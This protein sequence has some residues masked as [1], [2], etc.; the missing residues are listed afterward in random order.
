[1]PKRPD[2]LIVG[3]GVVGCAAAYELAKAGLAVAVVERG[4]PGCEASSAAAGMLSPQ[5]AVSAPNPM[6]N[7]G[8][9]SHALWGDLAS[10]LRERTGVDVEYRTGGSLHCFLDEGDEAVGRATFGWQHAAGLRA[11]MLSRE[12][13][14]ALEPSL[15]R[16]L[17]G[18]LLLPEDHWLNNP[19]L[20]AALA[21]AASFEGVEFIRAEVSALL[22]R[23][24]RVVGVS[25]G[26]SELSAGGVL[27]AAGAW[28]GQLAASAGLTI[29]VHPVRGQLLCLETTPR[30]L[31]HVLHL[32][33]HY[34]VPRVSGELLVGSSME[35]VGFVKQVTGEQLRAFLDTA[36]RLVP[37]LGP[38]PLK[39]SWAGFRPWAPDE[40]PV[41]GP[42]AGLEGL[43]VAT[44]HF[45]NGILLAPVTAR[46]IKELIVDGKA[47]SDLTPFLPDRFV[48]EPPRV[49]PPSRA[50]RGGP[51]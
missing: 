8:L 26:G 4:V 6:L 45:R 27:L 29:P 20:V 17:R 50:G 14:L 5:S 32:K 24:D 46:L 44:A 3:G 51:P 18:A 34:A 33:D 9:A 28:S 16:E 12:D 25:A 37:A 47:S 43:F 30:R 31:H 42:W 10:E 7:L 36:I 22:R 23:G 19:R 21:Q 40:R 1:M 13:V 41:I 38:L 2:L 11:E 39:A 15:S 35:W 48:R 49:S